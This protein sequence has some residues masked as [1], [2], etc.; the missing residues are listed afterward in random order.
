MADLSKHQGGCHCGKVRYEVETDMA[1]VLSCNC[2]ICQ[3]RGAL[4]T[5][6]E[7]SKFK[8]LSGE[9]DLTDYQFNKKIIHHLFCRTC[10]VGSFARGIGPGGKKMVAINVR[11]LDEVDLGAL[12]PTAFDGKS[13]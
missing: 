11:C 12:K 5:F 3:K 13:M 10:G 1:Q 6:V 2:S 7:A 8:L 9:G 4:L